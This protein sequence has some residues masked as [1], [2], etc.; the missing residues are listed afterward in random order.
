MSIVRLT[1]AFRRQFR[2][3]DS[4]FAFDRS[5]YGQWFSSNRDGWWNVENKWFTRQLHES[6]VRDRLDKDNDT[7][8]VGMGSSSI[9]WRRNGTDET[10]YGN[11][12]HMFWNINLKKKSESRSRHLVWC[13][14]NT[15]TKL[16]HS[17]KKHY[18]SY[19]FRKWKKRTLSI[20][21]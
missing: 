19:N 9:L 4:N 17:K 1:E 2:I 12:R 5:I 3:C 6:L 7:A 21:D 11:F 10:S 13:N 14:L 8:L 16:N 15:W 20:H 18:I